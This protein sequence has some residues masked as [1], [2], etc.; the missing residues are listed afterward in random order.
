MLCQV[1][2]WDWLVKGVNLL[3][4]VSLHLLSHIWDTFSLN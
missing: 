1:R 4:K 2:G 3:G